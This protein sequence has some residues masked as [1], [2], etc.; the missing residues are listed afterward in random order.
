[1]ATDSSCSV[2]TCA[3]CS[4]EGGT[5]KKCVDTKHVN[6]DHGGSQSRCICLNRVQVLQKTSGGGYKKN[7]VV[8][9]E[10][11]H[12]HWDRG[13]N[14]DAAVWI[15]NSSQKKRKRNKKNH[16]RTRTQRISTHRAALISL[17]H[18]GDRIWMSHP[19]SRI[20]HIG[21]LN[22]TVHLSSPQSN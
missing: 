5:R 12:G 19:I 13:V 1:M 3:V 14:Q 11:K 16:P 10:T 18:H 2:L 15:K 17:D 7:K 6:W 21:F 8:V 22:V 20:N 4:V 9:C